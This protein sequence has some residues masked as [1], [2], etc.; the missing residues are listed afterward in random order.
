MLVCRKWSAEPGVEPQQPNPFM[1][2]FVCMR[3]GWLL[4]VSLT[5]FSI[6]DFSVAIVMQ[7]A[8]TYLHKPGARGNAVIKSLKRGKGEEK[9]FNKAKVK[10]PVNR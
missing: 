3:L 6:R 7:I 1:R 8:F 9:A 2:K 5:V 10:V 4:H